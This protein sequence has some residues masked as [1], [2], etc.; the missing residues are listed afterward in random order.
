MARQPPVPETLP[1]L[2]INHRHIYA[3]WVSS[4][5]YLKVYCFRSSLGITGLAHLQSGS[6]HMST[7]LEDLEQQYAAEV[8]KV[9]ADEG[10]LKRLERGIRGLKGLAES[11]GTIQTLADHSLAIMDALFAP[12]DEPTFPRQLSVLQLTKLLESPLATRVPLP[13]STFQSVYQLYP[14]LFVQETTA[15]APLLAPTL[16]RSLQ[17]PW[18]TGSPTELLYTPFWSTVGYG[19]PE[20]IGRQLGLN[21]SESRDKED[22]SITIADKRRDYMQHLDNRLVVEAV[23]VFA[24]NLLQNARLEPLI[25]EFVMVDLPGR[26]HVVKLFINLVRWLRTVHVLSLLPPPPPARLLEP[27]MRP[28]PY[29]ADEAG[30]RQSEELVDVYGLLQ[31][32]QLSGAIRCA[33]L[34][35]NGER[36]KLEHPMPKQGKALRT[37]MS[38]YVKL[39]LEPVAQ[40]NRQGAESLHGRSSYLGKPKAPGHHNLANATLDSLQSIADATFSGQAP[41]LS[42]IGVKYVQATLKGVTEPLYLNSA[43]RA[44]CICE[45]LLCWRDSLPASIREFL[46]L[47]T[48]GAATPQGLLWSQQIY[49]RH[50]FGGKLGNERG[51]YGLVLVASFILELMGSHVRIRGAVW[52]ESLI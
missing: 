50:I 51:S 42:I 52:G 11:T 5:K 22:A 32:L 43:N 18:P 15:S 33:S 46:F 4:W 20:L 31:H 17:T 25:P 26:Q 44:V 9:D 14:D 37:S 29:P 48:I 28:S 1:G 19:L 49:H 23:S 40:L 39:R 30:H 12:F 41:V 27:F 2:A 47:N 6:T 16:V 36:L 34:E 38:C 8:V 35:A 7:P 13:P 21:I 24:L 10:L 3:A 45:T